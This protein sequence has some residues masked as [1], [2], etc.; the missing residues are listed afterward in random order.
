VCNPYLY[1]V[2]LSIMA[3]IAEN[4]KSHDF[5][6]EWKSSQSGQLL[7]HMVLGLW[8]AEEKVHNRR[9]EHTDP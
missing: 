8:R 7:A 1:P 2:I 9:P 3:D 5:F 4:D 6:H